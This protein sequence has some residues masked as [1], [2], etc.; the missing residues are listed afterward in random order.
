MKTPTRPPLSGRLPDGG[1]IL[2]YDHDKGIFAEDPEAVE[3][4]APEDEGTVED[5]P[6]EGAE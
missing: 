1:W 5:E 2:D 3:P 4:P 6:E